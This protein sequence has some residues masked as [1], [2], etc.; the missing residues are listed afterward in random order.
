MNADHIGSDIARMFDELARA[1]RSTRG[2]LPRPVEQG[3]IE[4]IFETAA[5]AP[6]NCNTQPWQSHVVSG[7]MRD[8]LSCIFME[9]IGAGKHTLDFPYEAKY[10]GIYR[11]RQ[12]DVGLLLYRALGVT[13]EDR[14]GKRGAFLRNLEFFDAPHVVFILMPDWCGIREACDVG[15]YAQNLMLS[16]R[17]HGV[18]SCPQTILGYDAESVRRELNIDEN[19]K[20][21]FGISFGY[22]DKSLPE[23]RI[24]PDRA[25]LRELVHFH[26]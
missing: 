2:F 23:N 6:S 7:A 20:L 26:S 13:R 5:W 1:R 11:R 9:T 24:V 3:I 12:V 14:D 4:Q 22:E 10:D 15:M 25:A 21:L 17:A 8:R 16:M 18:A 19:M